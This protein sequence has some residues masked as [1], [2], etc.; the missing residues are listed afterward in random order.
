MQVLPSVFTFYI[1]STRKGH[2][3][4]AVSTEC[5]NIHNYANKL[6]EDNSIEVGIF[7]WPDSAVNGK[8]I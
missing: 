6:A 3:K 1:F 5:T 8:W 2:R 4:T 7:S